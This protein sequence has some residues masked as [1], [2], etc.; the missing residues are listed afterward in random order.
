MQRKGDGTTMTGGLSVGHRDIGAAAVLTQRRAVWG[1]PDD[2]QPAPLLDHIQPAMEHVSPWQPAPWRL[3]QQPASVSV[4]HPAPL[5]ACVLP[6]ILAENTPHTRRDR[7]LAHGTWTS[8]LLLPTP[9]RE[10]SDW[11]WFHRVVGLSGLGWAFVSA[12]VLWEL[13][14]VTLCR[15]AGWG[16]DR[17]GLFFAWG[18]AVLAFGLYLRTSRER[19]AVSRLFLGVNFLV[20]GV[21]SVVV[22][23]R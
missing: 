13:F 5:R 17:G 21:L 18:L 16:W 7:P 22:A 20:V 2:R 3:W 23:T 12:A 11:S 6:P 9:Q 8:P 10:R 14:A 4:S 19:P 1:S 15:C